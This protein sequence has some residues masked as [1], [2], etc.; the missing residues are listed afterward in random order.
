[1]REIKLK[2][3]YQN[4][5]EQP[6]VLGLGFFDCVHL[7]HK[8]LLQKVIE[9]AKA[10]NAQSAVLTFSTNPQTNCYTN[11]QVYTFSERKICMQN[12]GIENIIFADFNDDFKNMSGE[13]FLNILT[14]NFNIYEVVAGN[15][16]TYGKGAKG[17]VKELSN[18]LSSK[19]I[20][21][22]IVDFLVV[23]GKKLSTSTIKTIVENGDIEHANS[24][25]SEP[26]F[27]LST[28]RQQNGRGHTFG[29]PTAN[30]QLNSCRTMIPQGVYATTI[31]L[32]G[33]SHKCVTNVGIKPTFDDNE[34]AVE[35][36]ILNFE[37]DLYGKQVKL[38]F[39]KK[40]RGIIKFE[41]ISELKTQIA[42]DIAS[43][44]EISK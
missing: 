12:L 26:Y 2:N 37:G 4:F 44:L 41:N 20:K 14:S 42:K 27:F 39:W 7:G 40:L 13:D 35:S 29:I 30:M 32:D 9:R 18:F 11:V 33:K 10:T 3:F 36:H 28:V 19:K 31:E 16:F 21:I 17:G 24:L 5:N 34:Y 8:K 25:L 15:D 6:I 1:M 23:D 43:R 38:I 22:S